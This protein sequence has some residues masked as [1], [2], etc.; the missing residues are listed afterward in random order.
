MSKDVDI[1]V[2]LKDSPTL[3]RQM[4]QVQLEKKIE[5]NMKR[6][7]H[8]IA[9]IS[10]KGG[11][12]KTTVA[13]NLA[14]K[15]AETGKSTGALDVDITGPNMHKLLMISD[16]PEID[17]VTKEIIPVEG[18]L[19]IKVMSTAFL[20]ES[21]YTPVIW[22]GPM[23]MG[24]IREYLGTVKW[25]SLE[26][27]VIDLPPGTGD[28]TLD[29]MQLVKPLDGVIVVSTSQ[30]MSLI[31]VAKTINMAKK[32]KV[33]VLGLIENMSQYKCPKCGNVEY[34]FGKKDGV[35]DLAA[36][37]NVPFLG[38]IPLE[39]KFVQ[40]VDET[41]PVVAQKHESDAKNAFEDIFDNI[42]KAL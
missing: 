33:K 30:E 17:P 10:G 3:N 13:A 39:P 28:E 40:Q 14:I 37:M 27:M 19:N 8:K 12:G 24:V 20:L 22:R 7:A 26:Y 11:V 42:M 4:K 18:P 23:K 15:F 29:I 9:I 2:K 5:D 36:S 21:D 25:G 32:M 38:S 1:G 16:R 31:D 35:K 34:I 41:I 6:I